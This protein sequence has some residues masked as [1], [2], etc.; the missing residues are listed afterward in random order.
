M[1]E[2][3]RNEIQEDL[4]PILDLF[5]GA[6]GGVSFAKLRH[7]LLPEIYKR[8]TE[9]EIEIVKI[10]KQFSRLCEHMLQEKQ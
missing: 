5:A 3:I 1:N 2:R 6:D 10:V 9:S 8:E 7:S 4:D